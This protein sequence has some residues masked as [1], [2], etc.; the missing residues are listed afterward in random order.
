MVKA[1]VGRAVEKLITDAKRKPGWGFGTTYD[2]RK[3]IGEA[4]LLGWCFLGNDWHAVLAIV[5]IAFI[6]LRMRDW[7][8]HPTKAT[9]AEAATDTLV[10][11]VAIIVS[12]L[13]FVAVQ[14]PFAVNT[15]Q[16]LSHG[17]GWG[18]LWIFTARLWFHLQTAH[19]DFQQQP[20]MRVFRTAA[21]LTIM[22]GLAVSFVVGSGLQAVPGSHVRDQLLAL[23]LI[24]PA[25]VIR[26]ILTGSPLLPDPVLLSIKDP[27]GAE[28]RNSVAPL[29]RLLPGKQPYSM[30][31]VFLFVLIFL[32]SVFS[33]TGIALWRLWTGQGA[34]V[35][36]VQ[37]ITNLIGLA[38]LAP[39]WWMILEFNSGTALMVQKAIEQR[40]KNS[41]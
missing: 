36:W 38:I 30:G 25:S 4:V 40:E 34:D 5:A 10:M 8:I 12:Q 11:A 31:T 32:G 27:V 41:N 24:V 28:M 13:Y 37:L 17:V 14:S 6:A 7:S 33:S 18:M 9:V 20:E 29:P 15:P 21:R 39:L 26:R 35:N 22:L 23:A 16:E 19:N 1:F 3:A 2:P